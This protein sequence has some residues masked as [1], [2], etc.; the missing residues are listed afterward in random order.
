MIRRP[1]RST[2]FPYTTLFRSPE[3]FAIPFIMTRDGLWFGKYPPGYPPVLALG[4]LVDRPWLVN[5]TLAALAVGLVFFDRKGT[6]LNSSHADISSAVFC[7]IKNTC[8]PG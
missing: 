3:F 5:P 8:R 2:H 6:R 7:L 1:P 4:V